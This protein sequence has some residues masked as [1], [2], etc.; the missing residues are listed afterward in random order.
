MFLEISNLRKSFGTYTAVHHFE[1]QIERGEFISFLGPSGCGKTTTLRMIAGFESPT[2][3]SIRI[4]GQDVTHLRPNQRKIGMVFQSYALFP[5]MTVADNVAFGLKVAKKPAAEIAQRVDEMLR[6]IKLPQLGGRYPFQLS[7]GQQQRVALARALAPKPQ[8]LLLDEPLSALDAKIRV[9]LREEIRAVQ[10]E[11]GITT[12]YVTHDQEEALSMS[13]RIVVMNEGRVEQIGTQTDIYLHPRTPFVAE[14]IGANNSL[15]GTVTGVRADGDAAVL[16]VAAGD[17]TL[18]YR[19]H[20]PFAVGD[21]VLAYIRPE[22]VAVLDE[23]ELPG[24]DNVVEG[25]IDRVIFEGATAQLRVDVGGREVRADISGGQRMALVQ[26]EGRVRLAFDHLTLIAA[27]V[28]AAPSGV[29]PTESASE[30]I[31]RAS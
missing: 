24:H 5:N 21:P 13:D 16:T 31:D 11:L 6:L 23:G 26:H 2:E 12:V 30:G 25:I 27:P 10:R 29:E 1:M 15:R 4:A 28:G 17:I 22:D 19:A 8:V 14:F 18:R 7:G 3:G 20:E 9:S